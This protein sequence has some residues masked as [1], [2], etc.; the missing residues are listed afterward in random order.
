MFEL[1]KSMT[2]RFDFF[3]GILVAVAVCCWHLLVHL[4]AWF[5]WQDSVL[6]DLFKIVPPKDAS[7][8]CWHLWQ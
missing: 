8:P 5:H 4:G 2:G 1:S 3:I 6:H 7:L